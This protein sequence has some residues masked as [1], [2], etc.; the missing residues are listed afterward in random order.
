MGKMRR[1]K[2]PLVQLG[3]DSILRPS[4]TASISTLQ[5]HTTAAT[6]EGIL[7][8]RSVCSPRTTASCFPAALSMP[9][10]ERHCHEQQLCAQQIRRAGHGKPRLGRAHTPL[11]R[12]RPT[13]LTFLALLTDLLP[14][15]RAIAGMASDYWSS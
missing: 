13:F 6:S 4:T 5:P 11:V 15:L 12:L 7:R 1:L 8:S 2:Y 10:T 14:A 3:A 9:S